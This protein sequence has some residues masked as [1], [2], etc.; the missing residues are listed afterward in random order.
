MRLRISAVSSQASIV[1]RVI[2]LDNFE[3]PWNQLEGDQHNVERILRS[4]SSIPLLSILLTMRSNFPP[5]EEIDWNT[6]TFF[7]LRGTHHR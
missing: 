2:L 6:R 1:P 3:T 5:S 7:Q 4:L